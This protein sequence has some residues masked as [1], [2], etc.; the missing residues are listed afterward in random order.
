MNQR[1][2]AA[3]MAKGKHPEGKGKVGKVKLADKRAE[4]LTVTVGGPR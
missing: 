1:S 2:G 3:I 4:Q